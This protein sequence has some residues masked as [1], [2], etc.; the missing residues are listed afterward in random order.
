MNDLLDLLNPQ[1][2]QAVAA[3]AGPTLVWRDLAPA[4]ARADLPDRLP[5]RGSERAGLPHPGG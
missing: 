5:D 2:Q 4:N 1:Q 3:P